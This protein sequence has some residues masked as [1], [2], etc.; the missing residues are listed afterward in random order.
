M[1]NPSRPFVLVPL[2]TYHKNLEN[3]K[4]DYVADLQEK[5]EDKLKDDSLIDNRQS[6]VPNKTEPTVIQEP[7]EPTPPPPPLPPPHCLKNLRL[8]VVVL[9][10]KTAKNQSLNLCITWYKM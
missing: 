2:H 8:R 4:H 6:E 10:R 9:L 5:D 3:R 7:R 1:T